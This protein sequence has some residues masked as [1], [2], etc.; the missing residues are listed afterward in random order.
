MLIV[1]G[2]K[3]ATTLLLLDVKAAITLNFAICFWCMIV[4]NKL[5]ADLT[6]SLWYF[7]SPCS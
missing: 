5:A 1:K 4:E 2:F 7:I 6:S 3:F